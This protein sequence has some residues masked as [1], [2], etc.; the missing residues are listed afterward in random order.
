MEGFT[1]KRSSCGRG[2]RESAKGVGRM[3]VSVV[4]GR[5]R[6]LFKEGSYKTSCSNSPPNWPTC[7]RTDVPLS[8]PR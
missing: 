2:G 1:D 5:E 8:P 4:R 7:Q 3:K 6:L